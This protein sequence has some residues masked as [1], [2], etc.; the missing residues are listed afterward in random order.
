MDLRTSTARGGGNRGD[1]RG[2]TGA[3]EDPDCSHLGGRVPA[4]EPGDEEV[5]S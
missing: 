2:G 4:G 3:G 1:R 5:D